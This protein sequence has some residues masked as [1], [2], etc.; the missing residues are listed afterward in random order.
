MEIPRLM[1]EMKRSIKW[2]FAA[3]YGLAVMILV[4]IAGN[5]IGQIMLLV[6]EPMKADLSLSDAQIGLLRGVA[7]TLVVAI[8]AYPIAWLADRIDRRLVF[9]GC[10]LIWS[11]ATIGIGLST[12]FQMLFAMGVGLAFGEAVLGPVT[13][14]IIP[15]L[16]PPER[17]MLA[18]SIFFVSQLLG[19]AAGLTVG[20]WLIQS[21]DAAHASLPGAFAAFEQWRLTMMAAALP[22]LLLIPVVLLLRL[23]RR[24]RPPAA[25]DAAT[26]D[27]VGRYARTHWRT[28]ASLFLGFGLIGAAN[29]VPFGWLP[30]VLVRSFGEPAGQVGLQLGQIFAIS[31]VSG[32]VAA[33]VLARL[34]ARRDPDRAPL[35]VAQA[36]ALFAALTSLLYLFARSP[37][38]FYAIAAFQMAASFGG[39]VLSP[40]LTQNVTPARFRARLLAIGGMFYIGFGALSPPLVGFASDRLGPDP[41]SLLIAMILVA[42]PAFL[43]G[44]IALQIGARRLPATVQAARQEEQE[45]EVSG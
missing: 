23:K 24:S 39:L 35:R 2:Q 21:I 15:E 42:V 9:A 27:G 31:S 34:I 40:T 13:F 6:V 11:L 28:L 26:D 4:A 17:R 14:A 1:G 19:V 43:L 32:V 45:E 36:G 41:R 3:W 20:G 22:S 10:M 30:V 25:P 33:N 29:F 44:A 12:S 37:A 8:A 7:T 5:S 38:Q 16:F 18:N